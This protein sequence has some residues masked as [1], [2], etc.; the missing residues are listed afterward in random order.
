ML[1][2]LVVQ[3]VVLI[4]VL[5]SLDACKCVS[6]NAT[7]NYCNYKFTGIVTV[8]S[9]P[10]KCGTNGRTVSYRVVQK[11]SAYKQA[12]GSASIVKLTTASESAAC[13]VTFDI[14]EDYLISGDPCSGGKIQV[15]SCSFPKPLKGMTDKELAELKRTYTLKSC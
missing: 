5:S 10:T 2:K 3:C 11:G 4:A 1:M 8:K 12:K 15:G 9:G 13:G 14:G 7:A 6:E